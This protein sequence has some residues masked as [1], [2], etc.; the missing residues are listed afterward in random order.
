MVEYIVYRPADEGTEI[1]EFA[2]YAMQGGLEKI[3]FSW[4]FRVKELKEI[5]DERLINV[6]FGEIRVKVG[7]FD[8]SE[9]KFV[10][11]LEMGPRELQD[12]FVFLWIESVSG[13]IDGRGY[14]AK[15]VDSKH[16]HNLGVYVFSNHASLSCDIL[17]HFVQC[18]GFNLF[19]LELRTG[20]IE[21][22]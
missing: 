13:R 22:E 14:R 15:E 2:I 8:E 1:E 17:E 21:V 18:L 7:T 3:A 19:T 4:I 10:D 11:N 16:V 9:E 20:V 6:S 12:R 5:K